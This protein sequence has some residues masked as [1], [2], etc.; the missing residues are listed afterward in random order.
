MRQ[1]PDISVKLFHVAQ[2]FL[3]VPESGIFSIVLDLF[4]GSKK[5]LVGG[6]MPQARP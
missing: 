2:T 1:I 3:D 6:I 5:R 4:L